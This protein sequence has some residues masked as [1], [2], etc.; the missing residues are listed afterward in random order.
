MTLA[1]D[2][3]PNGI[4]QPR[5]PPTRLGT[6]RALPGSEPP[7]PNRARTVPSVEAWITAGVPA[8]TVAP[9]EPA[10]WESLAKR[11]VD[12]GLIWL[13]YNQST[14][15][16]YGT[17]GFGPCKAAELLSEK[18][19]QYIKANDPKAKVFISSN[20]ANPSVACKWDGVKKTIE[21]QTDATVLS[22]QDANNE[23]DGLKV[24]FGVRF[25][26]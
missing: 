8:I 25:R 6:S 16:R 24:F 17:F 18:I 15:T 19:V 20:I 9:F 26:N 3:A 7:R 22:F 1:A 10:A 11:A 2:G 5:S 14:K 13:S 4:H 12:K 23:T 21:D